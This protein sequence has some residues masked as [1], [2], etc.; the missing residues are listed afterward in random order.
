MLITAL[1][2]DKAGDFNEGSGRARKNFLLSL[3]VDSFAVPRS[4]VR[5]SKCDS[6]GL[7]FQVIRGRPWGMEVDLH[8]YRRNGVLL[9]TFQACLR[10]LFI[11]RVLPCAWAM[12]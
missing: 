2:P 4:Q 9:F 5:R 1:G 6:I 12:C 8:M 3:I 11:L 10:S 7:P